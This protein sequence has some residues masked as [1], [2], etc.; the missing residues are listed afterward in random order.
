MPSL[1][2]CVSKSEARLLRCEGCL[3]A[4]WRSLV[5]LAVKKV[6]EEGNA[7]FPVEVRDGDKRMAKE[8]GPQGLN[9]MQ[10]HSLQGTTPANDS[11]LACASV[12]LS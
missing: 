5:P 6:R 11:R 9:Q 10:G 8:T 3:L 7:G 1:L 12:F 4:V 2:G